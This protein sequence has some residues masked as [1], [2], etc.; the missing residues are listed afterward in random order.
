VRYL[1]IIIDS[2]YLTLELELERL[3]DDQLEALFNRNY[4]E[5]PALWITH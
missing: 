1:P 4:P 5:D 3:N 2:L